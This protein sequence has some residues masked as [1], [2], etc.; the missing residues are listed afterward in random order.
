MLKKIDDDNLGLLSNPKIIHQVRI[1]K[2]EKERLFEKCGT[3]TRLHPSLKDAKNCEIN[4][5]NMQN[6]SGH[7]LRSTMKNAFTKT[8]AK[9]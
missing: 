2:A 7:N 3:E 5:S 6:E 8:N 9:D 4:H 1:E